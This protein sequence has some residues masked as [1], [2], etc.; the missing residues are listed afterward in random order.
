MRAMSR[1][2]DDLSV[3]GQLAR[4][5]GVCGITCPAGGGGGRHSSKQRPSRALAF[6]PFA[7]RCARAEVWDRAVR[8]CPRWT[9]GEGPPFLCSPYPRNPSLS[10]FPPVA[11]GSGHNPRR[12][13]LLRQRRM[14]CGRTARRSATRPARPRAWPSISFDPVVFAA[15]HAVAR[16]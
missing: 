5:T 1:R 15:C 10:P 4:R 9:R 12:L 13:L 3:S 16:A 7:R 8:D 2:D 11:Q 6:G 14:G